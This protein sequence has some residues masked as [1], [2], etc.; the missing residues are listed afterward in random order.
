[1]DGRFWRGGWIA[2]GYPLCLAIHLFSPSTVVCFVLDGYAWFRV[3]MAMVFG[4]HGIL[5]TWF[6]LLLVLMTLLIGNGK[7]SWHRRCIESTHEKCPMQSTY[8]EK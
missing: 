1:L 3:F 4:V 6:R 7:L 5:Y 2:T 8:G